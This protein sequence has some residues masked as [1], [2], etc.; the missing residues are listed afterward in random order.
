MLREPFF[1]LECGGLF[2]RSFW[3]PSLFRFYSSYIDR[4]EETKESITTD[5]AVI[6]NAG[7]RAIADVLRSVLVLNDFVGEVTIFVVHYTSN[8]A[9][10][11][12]LFLLPFSLR[13]Y[14][15][16]NISAESIYFTKS[17]V[18]HSQ[19]DCGLSH[20]TDDIF[21]PK[22]KERAGLEKE[23]EVDAMV[24]RTIKE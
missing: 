22:P 24:F 4:I 19:T 3:V 18:A 1:E 16:I 6:S 11:S 12:I 9:M 7:G 21:K 15:H 23:Q 17:R 13:R 5:V 8:S 14:Q 20:T 10:R 2:D